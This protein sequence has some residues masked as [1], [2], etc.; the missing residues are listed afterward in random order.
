MCI[1]GYFLI[2]RRNK[3]T[4][5]AAY[6]AVKQCNKQLPY[7]G[8]VVSYWRPQL[9]KKAGSLAIPLSFAAVNVAFVNDELPEVRCVHPSRVH[10]TGK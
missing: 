5:V 7:L 4:Q 10:L 8:C 2:E 1:Y 6:S 9:L 3:L